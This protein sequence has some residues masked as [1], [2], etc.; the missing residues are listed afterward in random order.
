[1][2]TLTSC[3]LLTRGPS[4]GEELGL[5]EP[6]VSELDSRTTQSLQCFLALICQCRDG[7]RVRFVCV[8][9]VVYGV[10]G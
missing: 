3:S 2:V 4:E 6:E 9:R 10:N 1:M 5:D 8:S 7:S